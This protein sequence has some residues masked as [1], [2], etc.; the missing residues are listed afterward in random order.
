MGEHCNKPVGWRS[1][2]TISRQVQ[3]EEKII[4]RHHFLGLESYEGEWEM[5]DWDDIYGDDWSDQDDGE[6]MDDQVEDDIAEID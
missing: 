5:E 2:F 4:A 6:G 3:L 1:K